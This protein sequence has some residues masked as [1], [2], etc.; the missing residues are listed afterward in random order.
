M[1][2]KSTTNQNSSNALNYDPASKGLYSSLT[3]AGG[4]QLLDLINNPFGNSLYKLG[5][6][7]SQRGAQQTGQQ[8]IQ[9]LLNNMKV[10][11]ISGQAGNAFQT[12]QLNKLGRSNLTTMS[13]ANVGNI[14]NA[15]QR[16]MTATGMGMS[17]N[18]LLTGET[19]KSTTTQQQS[20]LGTWLPQLLGGIAGAGLGM[21]TGGASAV[22]SAFNPSKWV[23]Q[24][25][26]GFAPPVNPLQMPGGGGGMPNIFAGYQPSMPSF[27]GGQNPLF[28]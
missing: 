25:G 24:G 12:A 21:A 20:G 16:Q 7:Q 18:P 3:G 17:F 13:N 15:L 28:R 26:Q 4:K 6:G 22:T 11:G 5:L 19:G 1:S 23:G 2:T 9:A 14:T 8:G 27:G 10:G